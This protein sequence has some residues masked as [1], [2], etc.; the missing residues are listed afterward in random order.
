[1]QLSANTLKQ[2]L[3]LPYDCLKKAVLEK[4]RINSDRTYCSQAL[5]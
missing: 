1:V 4:F 2:S 5:T 3:G